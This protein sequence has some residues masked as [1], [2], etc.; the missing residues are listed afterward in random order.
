M[1][2]D[3]IKNI[4]QQG[5]GLKIEFKEAKDSVPQSFYETVA[6]F[7]NTD[8][9]TKKSK[10]DRIGVVFS[11]RPKENGDYQKGVVHGIIYG[12]GTRNKEPKKKKGTLS[13]IAVGG[14]GLE[15]LPK[16]EI[17]HLLKIF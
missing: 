3:D 13:K 5:E 11:E 2:L 10:A 9:G 16:V 4:I 1:T 17:L 15:N 12:D 8:G 14:E 6:S 7:S